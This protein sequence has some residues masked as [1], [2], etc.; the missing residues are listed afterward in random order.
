MV[1]VEKLEISL[2]F[3]FSK[4]FYVLCSDIFWHLLYFLKYLKKQMYY[5]DS[6]F[7]S[8]PLQSQRPRMG[9][10]MYRARS[11]W[12]WS[13]GRWMPSVPALTESFSGRTTSCSGN[14]VRVTTGRR[15]TTPR[16]PNW[17][18]LSSTWCERSARTATAYRVSSSPT[19]WAVG[20]GPEWAPCWSRR[21]AR[22][23]PTGLWT[24]TR[25]CRRPKYPIPSW[26]PTT[27]PCRCIN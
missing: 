3:L 12:T 7:F 4:I 6:Y 21:S 26:N 23:I 22:S 15:A 2:L 11:C 10:N 13:R 16:A 1:F 20:P 27:R 5:L 25:W 24:L 19:R 17:S 8:L 18:T 9:G 14:P